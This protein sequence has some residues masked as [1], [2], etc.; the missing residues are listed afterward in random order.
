METKAWYTSKTVWVN[1][2]MIAAVYSQSVT[3]IEVT[4][5]TQGAILVLV[6]LVLRGL[7]NKAITLV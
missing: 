2:I 6:N 5:E 4:Q 1:L 7:T 3:G